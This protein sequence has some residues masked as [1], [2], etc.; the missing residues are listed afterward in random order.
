M[1]PISVIIPCKG[2]S[3]QFEQ[4]IDSLNAQRINGAFY[5]F[6]LANAK[7]SAITT[8]KQRIR[9]PYAIVISPHCPGCSEMNQNQ[10]AGIHHTP[11]STRFV[12]LIDADGH[13]G[14]C[15]IA[16]LVEPLYDNKYFATSAY[17][18]HYAVTF[19]G[20]IAKYW[21]FLSRIHKEH[22]IKSFCWG[23]GMAF[24]YTD[25]IKYQF[26]QRWS[27]ALGDDMIITQLAHRHRLP[28]CHV[29]SYAMSRAD[30]SFLATLEWIQHQTAM[31]Y[32]YSPFIL[33]YYLI[34]AIPVLLGILLSMLTENVWFLAPVVGVFGVFLYAILRHG[35][36]K[37][38]LMWPFITL[39]VMVAVATLL[40]RAPFRRVFVWSGIRYTMSGSG[41]VIGRT[42]LGVQNP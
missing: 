18:K 41:R 32:F 30:R 16:S 21:D 4:F 12:V 5:R 29:H 24:R 17:R 33:W 11:S 7:D 2:T 23:G 27:R 22:V 13:F 31:V 36:L 8:I 35:T 14:P 3:K 42:T 38:L 6:C 34:V 37:E 40:I 19:G 1:Y 25:V 28:V 15:H 9:K 20:M 10:I 26:A 39:G